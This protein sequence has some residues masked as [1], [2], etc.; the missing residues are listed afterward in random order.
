MGRRFGP[1]ARSPEG[2]RFVPLGGIGPGEGAGPIGL[3]VS[4][5]DA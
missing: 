4:V 5:V 2:S 1:L 3:A